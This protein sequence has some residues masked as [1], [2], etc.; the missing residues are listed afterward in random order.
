MFAEVIANTP[1]VVFPV[2]GLLIFFSFMVAV[3]IRA[4]SPSR[5]E[6]YEKIGSSILND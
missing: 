1:I 6:T 2:I 3:Y 5:K 4:F